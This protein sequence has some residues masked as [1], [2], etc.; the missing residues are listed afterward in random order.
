MSQKTVERIL[1]KL[2]TDEE[3]RQRFRSAPRETV[4]DTCREPDILTPVEREA[5]SRHRPRPPRA[6][7][8]RPRPPTPACPDPR[9]DDERERVVRA[10]AL[11]LVAAALRPGRRASRTP[12]GP[13]VPLTPRRGARPRPREERRPPRR[14]RERGDQRVGRERGRRART[15]RP[16]AP[17]PDGATGPTRSTPSCRGRRPGELAPDYSGYVANLG[18][19]QLLPTGGTVALT[20]SASRDETTNVF[21][22]LSPSWS[23]SIGLELRQPLLRNL[24]DRPRPAGP[25]GRARRPDPLGRFGRARHSG[26]G[27]RRR[28]RLLVAPRRDGATSRPG[29]RRS[30]SPSGRRRDVEAR[31]EAGTLSEADL[32]APVAELERR[33]GDLF[34][35]REAASRAENALKSLLLADPA[36]PLW[37]SRLVPADEPEA[38]APARPTSTRPSARR[39][40]SVPRSPRPPRASRASRSRTRRPATGRARSSTS[41]PPTP[42]AGSPASRTPGSTRRSPSDADSSSRR[43]R[44]GPRPLVRHDPRGALPRRVRRPRAHRPARQPRRARRRRRR[45][46]QPD[47]GRARA[48]ADAAGRRGRGE[49]RRGRPRDGTASGVAAARAGKAAAETQL[50]AEEER[51]DAGLTHELLRP[52]PAERPDAGAARRDGR[53]RRPPEGRASSGPAPPGRSSRS[54]RSKSRRTAPATSP[55]GGTR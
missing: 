35:S 28:A 31:V 49:E 8:R 13:D 24:S 43:R 34:A 1:G 41:S 36:D 55:E 50:G 25:P 5:L 32:A 52:D 39:P 30:P 12:P 40:R 26:D 20:T 2:A 16:S 45:P 33:R 23:T 38:P 10:L 18:I 29:S 7:R 19:A 53:A 3:V 4:A 6:L 47:P 17:T 11:L 15:T 27:R 51:F 21:S 22:I 46:L 54:A 42:A 44:R 48:P 37:S 9:H 14:A